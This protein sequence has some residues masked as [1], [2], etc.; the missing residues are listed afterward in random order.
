MSLSKTSKKI[1]VDHFK[2]FI[3]PYLRKLESESLTGRIDIHER[4][5]AWHAYV[6]SLHR[7]GQITDKQADTWITPAFLKKR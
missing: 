5:Q 1:A 7:G 3:L 2:S 6:D 4:N